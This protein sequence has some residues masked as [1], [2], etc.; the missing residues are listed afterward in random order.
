MKFG[1]FQTVQW[2]EG[3][4]QHRQYRNALEQ[5]VLADELGYHS[6]W[7]TEHHFTRHS[8]TSDSL[9]LLAHLAARTERIRLGTAVAVLPFHDP[10]RLAE[11]TALVDHLSQ[12]RLD[13]GIGRGYQ[14]SEY[15]GFGLRLDEGSDRFEEGLE[16]LLRSWAATEPFAFRG[17]FSDYDAAFPQPRPLQ[18]PHPPVWHATG[19][20]EGFRRCAEN[21]WG[22]MLPQ[23]TPPATVAGLVERFEA[24][25]GHSAAGRTVLARGMY[26]APTDDEALA[27]YIPPYL[28]T[29]EL[30]A[31]VSAP[32]TPVD[33]GR[34]RN[35]FQVD[36]PAAVRDGIV[37]GSPDSCAADLQRLEDIGV[38]YVIFF[39]NLGG[40]DHDRVMQSLRLF[41]AEVM[42][43]F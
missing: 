33:G 1:L 4:D 20:D 37:C 26:C 2:P 31:K 21:G 35:P 14:W 43:R 12:G 29:L 18:Q 25:L 7:M 38:D 22:V 8:I 24:Q 30:A 34:P 3:S 13:V 5:S 15:N 6:V 19:S 42:P 32:P 23:A 36:D 16:L 28:D 9:A 11:T 41:A 40:M 39:V 27:T 10:V 17:K